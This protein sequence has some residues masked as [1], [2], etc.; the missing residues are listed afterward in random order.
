MA[1]VSHLRAV[2][3]SLV[4]MK[5]KMILSYLKLQQNSFRPL[6]QIMFTFTTKMF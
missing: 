5:D 2:L 6:K 1:C 3:L 4:Q